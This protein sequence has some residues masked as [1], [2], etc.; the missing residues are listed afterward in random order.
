M[1]TVEFDLICDEYLRMLDEDL[2]PFAILRLFGHKNKEIAEI[3][4]C[5]NSKVERK[6]AIIR[7]Q[8]M[9]EFREDG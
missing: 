3:L 9:Q 8:W 1:P 5:S 2:Q 4:F 7:Q 6:L